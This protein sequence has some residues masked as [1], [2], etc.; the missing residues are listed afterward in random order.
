MAGTIRFETYGFPSKD[1]DGTTLH[2]A[3]WIPD[4]QPVALI[5]LVHGMCEFIERY[6]EFARFLAD[7]GFL[8]YGHDDVGHGQSIRTEDDLGKIHA[9]EPADVLVSDIVSDYEQNGS[10]FPGLPHFMLGHSMGS[11]LVRKT[12][13]DFSAKLPSFSGA[14]LVGTGSAKGSTVR[15]GLLF[16]KSLRRLPGG[17]DLQSSAIKALSHDKKEYRGFSVDGSDLGNNWLTRDL[18]VAKKFLENPKTRFIFSVNF[19]IA[20]LTAVD[21]GRKLDSALKIK[22]DL[23]ILIISGQED[24]V[25][26]HGKWINEV[27]GL[28]EEAGL[29]DVHKKLYPGARHEILNETNREEVYADVY[30]WLRRCMKKVGR[31]A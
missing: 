28:Y 11:F 5:Q 9:K 15:G 12:L 22:R 27:Y 3:R 1:D 19:Y 29:F 18:G 8:V 20:L 24:P 4:G 21:E 6:D 14:I 7:K 26:G 31:D 23:P 25:G 16:L 17:G 10:A 13:A 2:G 30:R